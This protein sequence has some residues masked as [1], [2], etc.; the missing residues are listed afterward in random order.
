MSSAK[1]KEVSSHLTLFYCS[2]C[3]KD[4]TTTPVMVPIPNVSA[5]HTN[6]QPSFFLNTPETAVLTFT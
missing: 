3:K 4:L 5:F 1:D 6:L 2:Q